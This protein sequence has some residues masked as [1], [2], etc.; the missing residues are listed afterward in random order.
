MSNWNLPH[1]EQMYMDRAW[2]KNPLA[3]HTVDRLATTDGLQAQVEE[4]VR[5][6]TPEEN[7]RYRA[8]QMQDRIR[9]E[10]QLY[11]LWLWHLAEMDEQRRLLRDRNAEAW[12]VL[13]E[14]LHAKAKGRKTVRIDDLLGGTDE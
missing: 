12:H 5:E 6:Y 2:E 14:V 8:W 9:R 4:Y 13:N 10:A 3:K 1:P 7:A 11:A